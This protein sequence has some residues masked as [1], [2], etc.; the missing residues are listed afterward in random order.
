MSEKEIF[1]M[2]VHVLRDL[3]DE[4]SRAAIAADNVLMIGDSE[5]EWAKAE[6]YKQLRYKVI[7]QERRRKRQWKS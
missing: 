3:E 1:D 4:A 6:F 2:L 7:K 5:N